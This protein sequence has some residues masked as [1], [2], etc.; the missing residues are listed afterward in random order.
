M[1]STI[2]RCRPK[3]MAASLPSTLDGMA[4]SAAMTLTVTGSSSA[5]PP[6]RAA[7]KAQNATIQVLSA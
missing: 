7:T 2:A 3:R 5:E 4:S 6:F 1:K